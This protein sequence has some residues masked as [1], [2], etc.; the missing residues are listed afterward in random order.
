LWI[1]GTSN[2]TS[3]LHPDIREFLGGRI[4]EALST[5]TPLEGKVIRLL[6]GIGGDRPR[7]VKEVAKECSIDPSRIQGIEAGAL[8]KLFKTDWIDHIKKLKRFVER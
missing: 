6:F 1:I 7:A 5:L 3:L 2:S 8:R 4:E